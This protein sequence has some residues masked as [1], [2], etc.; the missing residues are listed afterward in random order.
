MGASNSRRYVFGNSF[1]GGKSA[2][3]DQA[4]E[5]LLN[6]QL[7]IRLKMLAYLDLQTGFMPFPQGIEDI[8]GSFDWQEEDRL[9][10]ALY[11]LSLQ[12]LEVLFRF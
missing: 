10:R 8:L 12:F 5:L 11:R 7:P 4:L 1:D 9:L 6:G 3:R 2:D